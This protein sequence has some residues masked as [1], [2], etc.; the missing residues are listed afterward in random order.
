M[1]SQATIVVVGSILTSDAV[2]EGGPWLLLAL[3]LVPLV[4]LVV[5]SLI[6]GWLI[7]RRA[8]D[9][10][11]RDLKEAHA[12]L[13]AALAERERQIGILLGHRVDGGER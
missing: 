7:P 10:R 5:T 13:Q 1:A 11:V 4:V 2:I 8:H 3:T 9:E 6:R 12:A